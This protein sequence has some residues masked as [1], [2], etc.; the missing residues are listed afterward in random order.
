MIGDDV[1][2]DVI[3]AQAVGMRGI[4]VRT[5]KYRPE[6]EHHPGKPYL[7]VDTFAKAV[8]WIQANLGGGGREK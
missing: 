5:G 7:V 6:D 3:A 2:T 8:Q 1:N 4:L